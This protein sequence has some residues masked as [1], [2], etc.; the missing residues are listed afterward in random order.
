[1]FLVDKDP[2]QTGDAGESTTGAGGGEHL[3]GAQGLLVGFEVF[4]EGVC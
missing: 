2:G 1:M 3:P 4:E